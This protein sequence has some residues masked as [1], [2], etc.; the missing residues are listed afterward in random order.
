MQLATIEGIQLVTRTSA[1]GRNLGQRMAFNSKGTPAEM[2]A[3]YK[4]AGLKG[5]KLSAAVREAIKG[6]KDLAWVS[7]QSL[8]QMAQNMDFVPAMGDLNAKGDKLKFEFVKPTA[9]KNAKG[10]E[11]ASVEAAAAKLAAAALVTALGCT[12][13]AAE[14]MI[15]GKPGTPA[16]EV[17]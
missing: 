12:L 9:P 11:G 8:L 3:A 1:N 10:S 4:A 7:A 16:L 15:S 5:N 14:A 13:E 6:G 17:K 2:R